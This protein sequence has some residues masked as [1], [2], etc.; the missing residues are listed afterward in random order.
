[1]VTDQLTELVTK[2][3]ESAAAD[4]VVEGPWAV[5]LE[6]PKRRDHGDWSTNV[7]LTLRG[8]GG[9]PRDVAEALV[10][11]LPP[12]E[13]VERVEVAGPGFL[14][15]YLSPRW[16]HEVVRRAADESTAFA[17][18][19]EGKG[20]RVNVEYVSANPT[21]PAGVVAGRAAAV[22]DTI[23]NL[24]EATGHEVTREYYINDAGRQM[25]L[26]ARSV[27]AH[28]LNHLGVGAS[29]PEE[30]YKGDYVRELAREIAEELG[31][32]LVARP[33]EERL[34]RLGSLALGRMIEAIRASLERFGTRFDNWF[35]ER[36][37]NER[38]AVEAAIERLR[39]A[40]WLEEREGAVW[41]RASALGDDKD[42]VLVRRDGRPTYLASDAAYMLDKFDRSFDRLI[43]VLGPD[44]HGTLARMRALAD[45]LG[46]GRARVE[47]PIVQKMTILS[48]GSTL[49]ASK[50]AG[51]VIALDDLVREV[52]RDA[53]RYTFLIRSLDA[54]LEFDIETVKQQTPENPVFYTQYAHARICS[55]LRRAEAE[56][57]MSGAGVA[58][59]ER[60]EHP[61][62]DRLMRKLAAYEEVV[63][64][65]AQLRA[66]QRI[67]RYVEELA[68][69]FNA[70]Y[71]D[72]RVVSDDT[73]L[74]SARLMLCVG[75]RRVIA[76]AL[77]L[78][79]V[80]APQRM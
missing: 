79:G 67:P 21:G 26:F 47:L 8:R 35:S 33:E 48:G 60:L 61:S 18:T 70:F 6:R 80:D 14:N 52:G 34:Q 20:A 51:V 65:A 56:G 71:R 23:A 55:I 5:T 16:L 78:L 40:G 39:S 32:E 74:T 63:P 38:G 69:D 77:A 25:T 43:Y 37:M 30:G 62:E 66:P 31:D 44:H 7:A 58:Q 45:A 17:R 75:T 3:L 72:C 27:E 42:R 12:S 54:P 10:E 28:Y 11:R 36:E 53:A 76:D 50:R 64:L 41:F 9:K 1:M 59:L 22:G 73:D 49:K 19:D 68:A 15:F 57:N 24:L 46:F 29:V 13:T 4:G 2:A